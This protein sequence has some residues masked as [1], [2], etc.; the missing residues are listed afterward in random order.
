MRF[1]SSLELFGDLL[2]VVGAI[3]FMYGW[4]CSSVD[5]NSLTSRGWYRFVRLGGTITKPMLDCISFCT[6]KSV[7]CARNTSKIRRARWLGSLRR[8]LSPTM[9]GMRIESIS[10]RIVGR[11]RT[12]IQIKTER[13]YLKIEQP[14][15]HESW[16]HIILFSNYFNPFRTTMCM[17]LSL[18]LSIDIRQ[19]EIF[20]NSTCNIQISR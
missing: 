17:S 19:R 5:T 18:F 7:M 8:S 20:L 2:L 11:T 9:Y 3:Q 6:T 12:I 1:L 10:L 15:R 4:F 13:T 14:V 16:H